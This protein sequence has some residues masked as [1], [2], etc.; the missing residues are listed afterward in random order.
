MALICKVPDIWGFCIQEGV[1]NMFCGVTWQSYWYQKYLCKEFIVFYYKKVIQ[2][3]IRKAMDS[4]FLNMILVCLMGRLN[5]NSKGISWYVRSIKM[6][7]QKYFHLP[8][9]SIYIDTWRQNNE[10]RKISIKCLIAALHFL[11]CVRK[12]ASHGTGYEVQTLKC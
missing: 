12:E 2:I 6:I 9:A 10:E 5:A 4:Y 8:F 3:R 11:S 1:W 7:N